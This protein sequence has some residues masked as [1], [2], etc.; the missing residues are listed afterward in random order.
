LNDRRFRA[1]VKA[2]L[3]AAGL[4]RGR[5]LIAAVS[6]GVDS[7]AL[8]EALRLIGS[9]EGMTV[10]AAHFNHQLR[11]AGSDADERFV[12][13]WCAAHRV[14]CVT[15]RAPA[16]G[17]SAARFGA[18][19]QSPEAAARAARYAFLSRVQSDA[20]AW[21]VATG[22]TMDDQAE[23]VLLHLLRG[24]GLAGLR[25][26][27]PVTSL[28][29]GDG[30]STV[31]VVRPLL[32]LRRADTAAYCEARG[33]D[34]RQD[35]TNEDL[36]VPRNR[37]RHTVLPVLREVSPA[38]VKAIARLADAVRDDVDLLEHDTDA[39]WLQAGGAAAPG[40]ASVARARFV[41]LHPALQR[42]VLMRMQTLAVGQRRKDDDALGLDH[43]E[44]MLAL[45]T[46]GAG[47]ALDLPGEVRFAVGYRLLTVS[48]PS[49]RGGD[50]GPFPECVTPAQLEVPGTA[51]LGNGFILRASRAGAVPRARS[52]RW[53]AYLRPSVAKGL[54]V[55]SRRPGDRFTP[56]GLRVSKKLQDFFVDEKVPRE[57]RDRI[58]LLVTDQGV[59]WVVGF[60]TADWALA[61]DG[62]PAVRVTALR[63][64][65]AE[66]P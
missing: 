28:P 10:I 65:P 7:M 29:A 39:A 60:R 13:E 41:R 64:T 17:M 6:G 47:T 36:R 20:G 55:R 33:I 45:A 44:A 11:G 49:S 53:T 57:W 37:L 9:G 34:P 22:H 15:G 3:L 4:D 24:S 14:Q 35:P 40:R 21:A 66:R 59:A 27:A 62:R 2:A 51:R 58:P 16:S 63:R 32:G 42:R 43:V 48:A 56:S 61:R 50:A 38:A 1:A 54:V 12:V 18:A 23:T 19:G 31:T 26:M 46:G 8:L 5:P 52:G 25:G 30:R